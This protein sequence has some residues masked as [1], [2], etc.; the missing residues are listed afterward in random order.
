MISK[1]SMLMLQET[2]WYENVDT[3]HTDE[4]Y[5]GAGEGCDFIKYRCLNK[6]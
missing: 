2:N 5:F 6:H 3:T 4:L 1:F